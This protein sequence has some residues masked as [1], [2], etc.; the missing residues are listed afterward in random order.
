[1]VAASWIDWPTFGYRYG[2]SGFY[3]AAA[4]LFVLVIVHARGDDGFRLAD[5]QKRR[6]FSLAG[7][8]AGMAVAWAAPVIWAHAR[9][10]AFLEAVRVATCLVFLGL[11]SSQVR[12]GEKLGDEQTA[13]G[14]AAAGI[15]FVL[16]NALVLTI[17]LVSGRLG[18]RVFERAPHVLV[19]QLPRFRGW[20]PQPMACGSTVL[21]AMGLA[22]LARHTIVRRVAFVIGCVVVGATFSFAAL[23]LPFVVWRAFVLGRRIPTALGFVFS[24]VLV[25]VPCL[26]LWMKPTYVGLGERVLYDHPP[27]LSY[28]TGDR[29]TAAMPIHAL[30]AGPLRLS[31][32]LTGYGVLGVRAATCLR[33][34]PLGVGGRNFVYECP[35]LA[36]NTIGQWKSDRS[37]HNA[38]G[39]LL[40]EGGPLVVAATVVFLLVAVR[41]L[42]LRRDRPLARGLLFAF[43]LAGWGGASPFQFPMAALLGVLCL[44]RSDEPPAEE[45]AAAPAADKQTGIPR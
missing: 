6:A 25:I 2:R 42:R 39:A 14:L 30:T 44:W 20:M 32:Y 13:D 40:A 10:A 12:R 8:G 36:M 34:H 37:A 21:A 24:G 43:L 19:G 31:F 28:F 15:A 5:L 41:K 38:Y 45:L 27:P 3:W 18:T 29:G 22:A 9:A 26:L 23:T 11:V 16:I 35:V 4:C 33:E 17:G 1:V 7:A